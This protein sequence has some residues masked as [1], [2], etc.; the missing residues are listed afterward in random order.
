MILLVACATPP[1]ESAAPVDFLPTEGGWNITFEATY[2][3]DCQLDNMATLQPPNSEWEIELESSGFTLI[4]ETGYPSYCAWDAPDFA[5]S[6]GEYS[7]SYIESGYDA[8]ETIATDTYGTFS[9]A[10]TF[11]AVLA[12][13]ASCE[14]ADCG[15]VGTQYGG[16]FTYPCTA[17]GPFSGVSLTP[18]PP[19][20]G[21]RR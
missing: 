13:S 16:D 2:Q 21:A 19:A 12:I 20:S 10:D 14:G 1:E 11:T 4:D 8:I 5:C 15:E 9:D 18:T 3:G 6:D 17:E 7:I